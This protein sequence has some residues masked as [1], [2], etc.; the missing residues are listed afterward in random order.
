MTTKSVCSQCNGATTHT[1]VFIEGDE[2]QLGFVQFASAGK[3]GIVVQRSPGMGW[4]VRTGFVRIDDTRNTAVDTS[5]EQGP[6]PEDPDCY[7][8]VPD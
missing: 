1:K 2:K 4:S 7:T 3:D 5:C 6:E 8:P